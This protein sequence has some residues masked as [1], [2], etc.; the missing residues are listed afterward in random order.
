VGAPEL[1]AEIISLLTPFSDHKL[2]ERLD[3]L[4]M[5][6]IGAVLTL[7][8]QGK[9]Q[10]LV[11]EVAIEVNRVQKPRGERLTYSEEKVGH[12]LKKVGLYARRLGKAGR[13][14]VMDTAT[15]VRLHELAAVY[16]S[17][18]SDQDENNL[19]CRLCNENKRP[20]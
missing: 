18:G 3:D 12:S 10:V 14:L 19:H 6:A 2:A 4:G 1:Q 7:C 17:A 16:G 5:L 20:M 13:G 15:M 8:H 9:N 11:G